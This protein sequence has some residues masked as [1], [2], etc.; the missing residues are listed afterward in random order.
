MY[1]THHS[2]MPH[3][4]SPHLGPGYYEDQQRQFHNGGR[5]S[6]YAPSG[7]G[8]AGGPMHGGYVNNGYPAH[9]GYAQ[10]YPGSRVISHPPEYLMDEETRREH[11]E[12]R[13]AEIM[14]GGQ[15]GPVPV[16]QPPPQA[17]V[18]SSEMGD[19][20]TIDSY[21]E[22]LGYTV[23]GEEPVPKMNCTNLLFGKNKK[24]IITPK[25]SEKVEQMEKQV[26]NYMKKNSSFMD[27]F[28]CKAEPVQST[29][30]KQFAD[31]SHYDEPIDP[32][33]MY[34]DP[35]YFQPP[36]R[37]VVNPSIGGYGQSVIGQS[38]GYG[39]S[40]AFD[41]LFSQGSASSDEDDDEQVAIDVPRSKYAPREIV[42]A[43]DHTDTVSVLSDRLMTPAHHSRP[44]GQVPFRQYNRPEF[45]AVRPNNPAIHAPFSPVNNKGYGMS[46]PHS[47]SLPVK[48]E[49]VTQQMNG[50]KLDENGLQ[51]DDSNSSSL[52]AVNA[53][54]SNGTADKE[55]KPVVK[56]DMNSDDVDRLIKYWKNR[57]FSK[58]SESEPKAATA[59]MEA[60]TTVD[61]YQVK[62]EGNPSFD[63]PEQ[64][65][66][67]RTSTL[68][69]KAE[70]LTDD[71][72]SGI[73]ARRKK[74]LEAR[75]ETSNN[76]VD[77]DDD[78]IMASRREERV[79]RRK[80]R[81]LVIKSK[82]GQSVMAEAK[83]GETLESSIESTR[84]SPDKRLV[85]EN[86][87]DDEET[88]GE[89]EVDYMPST[90]AAAAL[91]DSM[92][93]TLNKTKLPKISEDS[94]YIPPIEDPL[95]FDGTVTSRMSRKSA[96]RNSRLYRYL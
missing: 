38:V 62:D 65:P 6:P 96:G 47:S 25:A 89:V 45:E 68:R 69:K 33:M 43:E 49:Q 94:D 88:L 21:G 48:T 57:D 91:I 16:Q 80:G 32:P 87:A 67:I 77:D 39:A 40:V 66:R 7:Y 83:G 27:A 42:V 14:N 71:N 95:S 73:V 15:P 50:M 30:V 10:N 2:A 85:E 54:S 61:K 29:Q 36:R 18:T 86:V 3:R 74:Y 55:D 70:I 56:K 28:S 31:Y 53:S 78:E 8:P 1:A 34:Y 59:K 37:N 75:L 4:Y 52:F 63:E 35:S 12:A 90:M 22:T 51:K 11:Q 79:I 81:S 64:P 9:N 41:A 26:Q 84:A 44:M 46:S 93:G 92:M 19:M 58:T 13:Y 24:N 17:P 72:N 5:Y 20:S 23:D 82:E 76:N 60:T